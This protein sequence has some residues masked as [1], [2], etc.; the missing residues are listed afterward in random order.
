MR[1]SDMVTRAEMLAKIERRD[2]H[3]AQLEAA[4]RQERAAGQQRI[5]QLEAALIEERA[6]RNWHDSGI[7]PWDL[8][9]ADADA[10]RDRCRAEARA[11]LAAVDLL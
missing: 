10:L 7:G 5:A 2:W 11:E 1:Q 3:I 8:A 6:V 9:T 4:L